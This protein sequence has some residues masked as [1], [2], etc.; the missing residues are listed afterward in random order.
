MERKKTNL[1]NKFIAFSGGIEST[2]M[3]LIYGKD[4]KAIFADTGFEHQ[5]LYEQIEKVEDKIKEI[6]PNFEI[7][8]VKNEKHGT[9]QDYIKKTKFYPS[10][11]SRFCTRM[12]KIEPIDNYLK[13]YKEDGVILMIGLNIDETSRTGNHGNLKF[14]NYKYPLIENQ[15]NRS[16]C[17]EL[18]KRSNI[19]PLF[20]VYMKR[21]GCKGC[22]YKS[23][24][25]YEAMIHLNPDEYDEVMNLEIEIQDKR[26]KF[27]KVRDGMPSFTIFKEKVLSQNLILDPK[28]IYSFENDTTSCGVFCNR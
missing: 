17:I 18:L 4:A 2:T 23:K 3:C 20:P 19:L 16:T 26:G 5:K 14:V 27:Y 11:K 7:I 10:F 25:E 24:R 6:H 8:K 1:K 21:G 12:F 22:F 9:L 15:I 13:Q 28:E